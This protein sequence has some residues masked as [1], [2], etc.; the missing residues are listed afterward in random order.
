MIIGL[1]PG[2]FPSTARGYDLFVPLDFEPVAGDGEVESFQ[3]MSHL[4]ISQKLHPGKFTWNLKKHTP[5][6]P[7]ENHLNQTFIIMFQPL[8]FQG[9]TTWMSQEVSKR[10]LSGL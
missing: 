6:L 2:A 9:C 1:G 7:K 10:L 5:H 8:I 4:V 3:L